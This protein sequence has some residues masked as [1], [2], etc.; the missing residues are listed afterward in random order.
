MFLDECWNE[1]SNDNSTDSSCTQPCDEGSYDITVSSSK[2]PSSS[3]TLIGECTEG[4][5]YNQTCY[6]MYTNNGALVEI[7]YEKL[8][9]E[10]MDESA[11]YTVSTLLSNIGGQ[12]GLWLGMSVISVIEIIVLIIQVS[13]NSNI[14]IRFILSTVSFIVFS[15]VLRACLPVLEW[16]PASDASMDTPTYSSSSHILVYFLFPF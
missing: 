5:Y 11:A 12:I 2:W 13:S 7:Y 15:V 1:Q 9:Y 3:L 6:E 10:T 14:V 4:Q 8:N 16:L